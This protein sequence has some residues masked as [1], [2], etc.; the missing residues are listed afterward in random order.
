MNELTG[1]SRLDLLTL[2][3][4]IQILHRVQNNNLQQS[5][6]IAN[7]PGNKLLHIFATMTKTNKSDLVQ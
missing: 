5:L 1:R 3:V 6:F 2:N 4:R 7:L